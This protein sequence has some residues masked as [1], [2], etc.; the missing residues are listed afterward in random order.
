MQEQT[1]PWRP[2]LV[3][4]YVRRLRIDSFSPK[5]KL[6]EYF[7]P[8]S[9][10]DEL[11]PFIVCVAQL[12]NSIQVDVDLLYTVVAQLTTQVILWILF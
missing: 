7:S 9:I 3:R 10:L 6:K 2:P 11:D 12:H 1:P 8:F 5:E 4:T